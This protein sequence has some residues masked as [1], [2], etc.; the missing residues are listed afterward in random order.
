[1][2]HM[3]EG[4][5]SEAIAR[6]PVCAF[7]RPKLVLFA[8]DDMHAHLQVSPSAQHRHYTGTTEAHDTACPR[9]SFAQTPNTCSVYPTTSNFRCPSPPPSFSSFPQLYVCVQRVHFP[10][11]LC[12]SD[13]VKDHFFRDFDG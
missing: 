3:A 5:A 11:T 6:H 4:D 12:A 2:A 8:E 9:I 10:C 13:G 1:M 7:C